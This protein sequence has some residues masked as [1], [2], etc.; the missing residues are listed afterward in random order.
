MRFK[1]IAVITIVVLCITSSIASQKKV[2]KS[3]NKWICPPIKSR[4]LTREKLYLG[5][6]V[7]LLVMKGF[8]TGEYAPTDKDSPAIIYSKTYSAD[9]KY[10]KIICWTYNGLVY[11]IEVY[12]RDQSNTNFKI[13]RN[14]LDRKYG[15]GK[16]HDL[17][18]TKVI[19][20]K[21]NF[22]GHQVTIFLGRKD[23]FDKY[24]KVV[25]IYE[26]LD[27]IVDKVTEKR[28]ARKIENEL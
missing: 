4:T 16:E 2:K 6:P 12:F 11:R 17:L 22:Q 5:M 25:Y 7:E 21:T 27:N 3:S 23:V 8:V 9:S 26:C 15:K 24:L 19:V 1:I 20:Y 18:L 14:V 13:I 28:K 10:D